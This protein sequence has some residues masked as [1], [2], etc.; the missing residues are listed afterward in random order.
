MLVVCDNRDADVGVEVSCGKSKREKHQEK[1]TRLLAIPA[2]FLSLVNFLETSCRR[3]GP[4]DDLW[5]LVCS[6]VL[7]SLPGD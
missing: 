3:G 7:P 4:S 2:G 1:T 5:T 6:P